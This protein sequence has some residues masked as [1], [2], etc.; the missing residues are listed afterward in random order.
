MRHNSSDQLPFRGVEA[1]LE[2]HSDAASVKRRPRDA[3]YLGIRG[4]SQR[5]VQLILM[6]VI[7]DLK[8]LGPAEQH[9]GLVLILMELF[10]EI[11]RIN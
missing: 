10:V 5:I 11:R 6:I 7:V 8:D 1:C 2:N 9:V 4:K 3:R